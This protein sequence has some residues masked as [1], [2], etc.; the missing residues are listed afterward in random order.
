VVS[1]KSSKSAV[2]VDAPF[3]ILAAFDRIDHPPRAVMAAV[4]VKPAM[5]D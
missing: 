4:T 1:A 3:D 2:G 5:S